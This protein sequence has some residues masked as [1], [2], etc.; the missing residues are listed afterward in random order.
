LNE[1]A[2]MGSLKKSCQEKRV[3]FRQLF[4][5]GGLLAV[6]GWI[7]SCQPGKSGAGAPR[8]TPDSVMVDTSAYFLDICVDA[9]DVAEYRIRRGDNLSLLL[10]GLNLSRGSEI[11]QAVDSLL[12]PKKL[13]EGLP[14]HV[15]T[16][17]DTLPQVAGLVFARSRTD[18]VI[19]DLTGDSIRARLYRKEIKEQQ[20]YMEGS[21]QTS[22]WKAMKTQ[23]IDPLL[24]IHL[25]DIFAWQIDFFELQPT[26]SFRVFYTESLIDD[27]VSLKL[28]VDAAMFIHQGRTFMA[29]PFTQ[30]S[31]PEFFDAEGKSLR[32]AFLKAPLDFFRITSHFTNSRFHPV[33]KYYRAH[34]GVDY[35]APSG[36]PVKTIGDGK[37]IAK[38]FQEG[39]G[40]NYVK[41]Q[42]NSIYATSY[43]HLRGFAGGLSVGRHVRQGD[44]I[45]Y[46]GSTGL[47]TGP[48]LDFRVYRNGTPIN[49]LK[50]ESPP[51]YPVKA[52]LRDS[53]E[54]VK[55]QIIQKFNESQPCDSIPFI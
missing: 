38:G 55:Q 35:A 51:A 50:M 41:I 6:A 30:D 4:V 28:S 46:V 48:H 3:V 12:D 53:F 45:G 26:D 33:L 34:H 11:L 36:T 29:I 17:R 32:S 23:G 27:T 2:F 49:P 52:E 39:G 31:L 43:M 19:V 47:S 1:K 18:H 40:G 21:V 8:E 15:L 44:V 25:S 37:V 5:A 54:R 16:T 9:L 10:S 14:Y 22:L 20:Q 7:C 24:A 13:Y 42:H